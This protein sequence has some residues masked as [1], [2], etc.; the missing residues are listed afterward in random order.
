[1]IGHGACHYDLKFLVPRLK[2]FQQLGYPV[3]VLARNTER[4]ITLRIGSLLFIDSMS[5]IGSSLH[6]AST[7]LEEHEHVLTQHYF[8]NSFQLV[9]EKIEFPYTKLSSHEAALSLPAVLPQH[10]Y[11]NDIR[12][13]NIS[14]EEYAKL[15]TLATRFNLITLQDMTMLYLDLDVLTLADTCIAIRRMVREHW[16]LDAFHY[17]TLGSLSYDILLKE[18]KVKIELIHTDPTAYQ[19]A[20]RGVVGGLAFAE[21]PGSSGRSARRSAPA[22]SQP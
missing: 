11:Y 4:F 14:N 2:R 3:E 12:Q 21:K 6:K 8:P 5:F 20:E 7:I 17:P 22:C 9:K 10:E 16:Q 18:S 19:F 1:M 15:K 13:T